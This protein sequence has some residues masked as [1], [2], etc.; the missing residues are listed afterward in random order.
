MAKKPTTDA[1]TELLQGADANIDPAQPAGAEP[2]QAA[3]AE[4]AQA[5][6]T[7]KAR[8]L[9]DGHFGRVNEVVEVPADTESSEIDTDPA[10]VAYAESL[11]D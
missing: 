9:R 6:G 1:D 8:V 4:P 10:A 2:P 5:A 11:K 3:G 7:V